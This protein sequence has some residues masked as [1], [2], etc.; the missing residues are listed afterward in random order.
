[1]N[2]TGRYWFM[3]YP[4]DLAV[5][6]SKPRTRHLFHFTCLSKWMTKNW[7]TVRMTDATIIPIPRRIQLPQAS[8]WDHFTL[9]VVF[10][11]HISCT[12]GRI[13]NDDTLIFTIENGTQSSTRSASLGRSISKSWNPW[14]NLSYE[15]S[16]SRI[17]QAT[18]R[19]DFYTIWFW[20][21]GKNSL[22]K[23]P[24]LKVM[25]NIG[26]QFSNWPRF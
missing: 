23:A 19:Y 21:H 26:T 2:F 4:Y 9:S 1:M 5:F 17:R 3:P 10:Q 14:L 12:Y 16:C 20:D 15:K 8:I 22:A 7:Q 18:S 13:P 24:G 6:V 11:F 25:E